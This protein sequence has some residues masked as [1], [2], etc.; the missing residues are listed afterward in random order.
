[1]AKLTGTGV[2]RAARCAG[3]GWMRWA[4]STRD[5]LVH[6][7]CG[8]DGPQDR[9]LRAVCSATVPLAAWGPAVVVGVRCPRCVVAVAAM[10]TA[11]HR[12]DRLGG[13]ARL[14]GWWRRHRHDPQ[15][16]PLARVPDVTLPPTTVESAA[17]AVRALGV[18]GLGRATAP[19]LVSPPPVHHHPRAA[20]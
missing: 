2:Q 18:T 3:P 10:G 7:F 19:E 13:C 14:L 20:R 15:P 6:A 16:P 11:R 17:P 8:D 12:R 9:W 5:G 4:Q 1:M